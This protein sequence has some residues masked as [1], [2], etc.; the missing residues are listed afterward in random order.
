MLLKEQGMGVEG[1]V[2]VQ[3]RGGHWIV[4]TMAERFEPTGAACSGF[5]ILSFGI[6]RDMFF[7][8]FSFVLDL[9]L[10]ESSD[11]ESLS[12]HIPVVCG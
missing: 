12:P 5:K 3:C 4:H 11:M 10:T 2:S 6:F 8:F 7:F 1:K 9:E